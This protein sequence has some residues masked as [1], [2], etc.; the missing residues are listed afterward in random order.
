MFFRSYLGWSQKHA[1]QNYIFISKSV[2]RNIVCQNVSC[3]HFQQYL[4]RNAVHCNYFKNAC[5]NWVWQRDF[6]LKQKGQMYCKFSNSPVRGRFTYIHL[7]TVSLSR[8]LWSKT[9]VLSSQSK[10]RGFESRPMLDGSGV[11][12][13]PGKMILG[14]WLSSLMLQ[15]IDKLILFWKVTKEKKKR[16]TLEI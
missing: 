15:M 7:E 5:K 3:Y 11:K 6:Y 1:A 9:R 12:A 8:K 14:A 10:G 13:M 4:W 16:H 2:Y